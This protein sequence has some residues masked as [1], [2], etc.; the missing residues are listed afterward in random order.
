MIRVT[1]NTPTTDNRLPVRP[2]PPQRV[3]NRRNALNPYNMDQLLGMYNLNAILAHSLN[4]QQLHRDD[5]VIITHP[6]QL[7]SEEDEDI[8]CTVCQ[9]NLSENEHIYK[10]DC[11]HVFHEKCLQ[12]WA[13]YK[14]DCPL[15]RHPISTDTE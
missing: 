4:D 15:C 1:I 5:S 13:K 6:I 8:V 12:D 11:N 7:A 3:L 9:T 10:L 14:A 2:Q